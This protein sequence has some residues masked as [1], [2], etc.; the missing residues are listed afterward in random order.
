MELSAHQQR[1]IEQA[2]NELPENYRSAFFHCVATRLSSSKK[3][4]PR[5]IDVMRVVKS[6]VNR[7]RE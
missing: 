5:D 1:L 6:I 2:A 7:W 3:I 4:P